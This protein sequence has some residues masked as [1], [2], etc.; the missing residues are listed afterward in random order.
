MGEKG[1]HC[2]RPPVPEQAKLH[3]IDI[4]RVFS[5]LKQPL[6]VKRL[7]CHAIEGGNEIREERVENF[8][9]IRV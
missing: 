8:D 5:A 3:P 9:V 1:I 6:K 2:Y 7:L 4:S